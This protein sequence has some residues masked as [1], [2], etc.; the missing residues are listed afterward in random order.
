MSDV[1]RICGH[2]GNFG[3]HQA[4][5]MFYGTKEKFDYFQCPS[6][7][8]LQIREVPENIGRFYPDRYYSKNVDYEA[9]LKQKRVRRFLKSLRKYLADPTGS[10]IKLK[11]QDLSVIIDMGMQKDDWILDVGCGT[12]RL[13]YILKE[14]GF[15]NVF[16][17]DPFID[18]DLEYANGLKIYKKPIEQMKDLSKWDFIMFHHS[19]EHVT[20]PLE[21]LMQAKDLLTKQGKLIIRIPVVGYAWKRYGVDWY[22]LDAPR[23]LYL[24]SKESMKFLADKAGLTIDNITYESTSS[25]FLISENYRKDIPLVQQVPKPKGIAYLKAKYRKRK[26]K[27]LSKLLNK[28]MEGDQAAFILS[29][30]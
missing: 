6:C 30:S 24:H 2:S 22:Q 10:N 9:M 5:E 4:R 27:K 25:Q 20:N 29:I 21:V 14:A 16:G 3:I 15:R 18:H 1:C 19:F 11:D 13:L 17:T 8:C 28:N 7:G 12:G 23:H 26:Y